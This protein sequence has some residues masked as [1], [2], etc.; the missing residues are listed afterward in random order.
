MKLYYCHDSYYVYCIHSVIIGD[1]EYPHKTL[2]QITF[3][4]VKTL[5]ISN[6]VGL[7]IFWRRLTYYKRYIKCYLNYKKRNAA[8][9]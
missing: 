5:S 6:F 7:Y 1:Y 3:S 8:P 2:N 9:K 4:C